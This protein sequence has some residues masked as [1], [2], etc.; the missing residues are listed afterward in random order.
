MKIK[1]LALITLAAITLINIAA[2]TGCNSGTENNN[3]YN[4]DETGS[5][6]PVVQVMVERHPLESLNYEVM[7][8]PVNEAAFAFNLGQ[9]LLA[10]QDADDNFVFSPLSVWLPLAALVNA[11]DEAN[12][13]ALLEAL[14]AGGMTEEHLNEY[15]QNILYRITGELNKKYEPEFKSPLNIAN[16]LFVSQDVTVKQSF[17]QSFADNYLGTMFNVDFSSQQAVDEVN[18]WASEHTEGL[19][20]NVIDEFNPE[21]V[22]AITNAVYYSSG[23]AWEFKENETKPDVFYT[24]NGETSAE[25]MKLERDG[26]TYY[27]DERI[28][29]IALTFNSGGRLWILLP[30]NETANELYISLTDSYFNEISLNQ[31]SRTGTLMLP[32]FEIGNRLDLKDALIALG[33]PLFDREAAPLTGGLIE[34]SAPVWLD[35]AIHKA[36]IMIDEKGTT[37]SAVTVLEFP[38]G[39]EGR[40][41]TSPFEMS[42]NKPFVF[43]LEDYRQILFTG[44]VNNPAAAPGS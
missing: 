32:K 13:P 21:T 1:K 30:K 18:K 6:V 2:F 44:V 28:Q 35:E 33:I 29:A 26:Q 23:W 39:G 5:E 37:A 3:S 20:T 11:T 43:V 14:G 19:I 34:S 27:E 25:Y 41:P 22:A 15:T 38:L 17:A 7:K 42:C 31:T 8:A 4:N 16:A 36:M 40:Q 12:K 10:E 9:K 24:A